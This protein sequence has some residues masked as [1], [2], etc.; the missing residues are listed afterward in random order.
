MRIVKVVSIPPSEQN[1][2][3]FIKR[4]FRDAVVNGRGFV[5]EILSVEIAKTQISSIT[6]N[7]I[8]TAQI[9]VDF[10]MPRVGEEF[11]AIVDMSRNGTFL[12]HVRGKLRAFFYSDRDIPNGAVVK[13]RIRKISWQ[14]KTYRAI[15]ELVEED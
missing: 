12:A 13:L 4:F 7:I 5:M 14:N 11:E 8:C 1:R 10:F 6:A 15:G 2:E 3:E 9:E